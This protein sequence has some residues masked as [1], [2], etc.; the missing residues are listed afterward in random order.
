[1][2]KRSLLLLGILSG[3]ALQAHA[4]TNLIQV[5]EEALVSDPVFQQAIAQR[6]ANKEAVPL[7][8]APLLP[9]AGIAGGPFISHF[10]QAG[11]AGLPASGFTAKGYSVTLTVTQTVFNYSQFMALAGAKAVSRQ[12]DAAL[13]AATQDLMIR[14]SRAYFAVLKD[15]DNLRYNLANKNAYA[16]QLDQINQQYKVGLKTITDLYTAEAS[17]DTAS[18][19]YIGA[20]TT[21][22][23]DKENLRAITGTLYPTLASLSEK[24]PL[25]S[26]HP[27]DMEAW[28]QTSLLQ[29]WSIKAS[30]LAN[31]A[32]AE[33]IKQQFGGHLP[34]LN[35]QGSYNMAYNNSFA[36]GSIT[37]GPNGTVETTAGNFAP[38]QAHSNE[39][40]VTLNLGVPIFQGGQVTAQTRQAK[41]NYQVTSQRL[42]QTVRG[43]ANIARQSYLG[44]I[45][46]I[47]QIKAD[48]QAIKS[49]ISSLEGLEEGYRVGTQTLVDVLNQQQKVFQ[50][51]TQYA[52]DRFAYVNN[53]LLLKQAT[54]TLS[55]DDLRAINAWL[56][57][58][59]DD[60]STSALD[61]RHADVKK[62]KHTKVAVKS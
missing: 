52:T 34:T 55:Q 5:Y 40:I 31:Q 11:G 35:L 15:E 2:K 42:E 23:N 50:T 28:V 22:A 13:N 6:M 21:L 18:A 25:I 51:Q 37:T 26:P 44:I 30:Q 56:L 38:I 24:F 57:D 29:N 17:F 27:T 16:K 19:G 4:A 36:G 53:L 9:Q 20:Q 45:L 33:N 12:A 59:N 43:T 14:V 7:S 41:Y 61:N 48:Q 46:G 58:N 60:D 10:H 32:A 8:I 1:M 54:G 47:Q 62:H 3:F 49:T 39:A